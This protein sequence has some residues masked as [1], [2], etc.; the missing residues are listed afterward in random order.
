MF[1]SMLNTHHILIYNVPLLK[2][3]MY[4][5]LKEETNFAFMK[6]EQVMARYIGEQP[7][8]KTCLASNSNKLFCT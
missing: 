8:V 1:V 4:N 2:F 3:D 7:N 6:F 5:K